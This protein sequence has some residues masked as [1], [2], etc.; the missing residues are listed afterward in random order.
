MNLFT[1]SILFFQV[2]SLTAKPIESALRIRTKRSTGFSQWSHYSACSR[3]CGIGTRQR[4]RTCIIGPGKKSDIFCTG[5]EIQRKK[6]IVRA[7]HDLVVK[8]TANHIS[9]KKSAHSYPQLEALESHDSNTVLIVTTSF[10][11]LILF[12]PIGIYLWIY[13]KIL[14]PIKDQRTVAN[15]RRKSYYETAK[16]L[17]D[18]AATNWVFMKSKK[19]LKKKKV[20]P[21]E[22]STNDDIHK[23]LRD[24]FETNKW[25]GIHHGIKDSALNPK[26]IDYDNYI[27]NDDN[28]TFAGYMN[29]AERPPPIPKRNKELESRPIHKL[30]DSGNGNQTRFV[31]TQKPLTDTEMVQLHQLHKELYQEKPQEEPIY[32]DAKIHLRK[33]MASNINKPANPNE[34]IESSEGLACD[35]QVSEI[36]DEG[37]E[38]LYDTLDVDQILNEHILKRTLIKR[39]DTPIFSQ[40]Q[41]NKAKNGEKVLRTSFM[42]EIE[43]FP[44]EIQMSTEKS[45][46]IFDQTQANKS[47][48]TEKIMHPIFPK[49][50]EREMNFSPKKR[51]PTPIFEQTLPD[52]SM[53]P[54]HMEKEISL[55]R[56]K[57]RD[58][59]VCSDTQI[60]KLVKL[61]NQQQHRQGGSRVTHEINRTETD[62][63]KS[64]GLNR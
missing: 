15:R 60:A 24:S 33:D 9:S 34:T 27:F 22:S 25:T 53:L 57:R 39:R 31:R 64:T 11:L 48:H 50:I 32:V 54:E 20:V 14:C 47:K 8:L 23:R 18:K 37:E 40:S 43:T 51:R 26:T 62:Q 52:N 28:R 49:H 19:I 44:E 58:S 35:E 5:D 59:I 42:E 63:I 21:K 13:A 7:C 61:A 17:M 10:G 36:S 6:C 2:I 16:Y 45:R 12:F 41:A 30:R 55:Y 46:P 56:E 38:P 3:V 1:I 4:F 29:H